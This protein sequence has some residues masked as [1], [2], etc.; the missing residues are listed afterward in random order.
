MKNE[1]PRISMNK[2]T[3][4]WLTQWVKTLKEKDEANATKLDSFIK[5]MDEM[6]DRLN[7]ASL[8]STVLRNAN[9]AGHALITELYNSFVTD[10]TP[11]SD[12]TLELINNYADAAT[13]VVNMEEAFFT[14]DEAPK[15]E[16]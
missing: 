6:I 2:D 12:T 14:D 13:A 16:K 5:S 11:I 9:I 4:D 3:V 1:F 7:T 8:H 15:E 10:D